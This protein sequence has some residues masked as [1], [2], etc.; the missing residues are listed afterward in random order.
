M[1]AGSKSVTFGSTGRSH[2]HGPQRRSSMKRMRLAAVLAV[3]AGAV[4][5]AVP[6]AASASVQVG[7]S[8]WQW[9]NPLPQGNTLRSMSFAGNDGYAAGAFGTLLRTTDGGS[10]WSGLLERH[11]HRPHRGAGD[12][13]Q[14]GL[15][16]RRL[17]RAALRRR[18]RD[19]P[20]RGLHAR[21]VLAAASSSRRPGSSTSV[22]GFLVLTDGTVLRTDNNGDTFAQKNPLPGTP[23]PERRRQAVRAR[24][25][26]REHRHRRHRQRQA[27][28]HDRRR[29]LVD[30]GRRHRPLRALDPVLR[31]QQ[32]RRGG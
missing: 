6:A 32:R 17:R 2:R 5:A 29:E 9:G 12:R 8:G 19:V 24:L 28:P 16:R 10:T 21:R 31:R 7:S 3:A 1:R 18:R 20:A 30:A 27:L 14:R 13:R 22:T 4:A 11:L 15:R 25:H 26:R 23:R